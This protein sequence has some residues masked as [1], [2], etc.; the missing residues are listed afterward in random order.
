MNAKQG[1]PLKADSFD[2]C[3]DRARKCLRRAAALAR[4]RG[5]AEIQPQ[6]ILD[7]LSR[8]EGVAWAALY[9]CDYREVQLA[10][11]NR[12]KDE[13]A[14]ASSPVARQWVVDAM[15]EATELTHNYVG[16]EHL[17]LALMRSNP[18]LVGDANRVRSEV[19]RILGHEA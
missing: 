7:A 15:N 18:N 14:V 9:D 11:P 8:D 1:E 19:L 5:H 12:E 4:R 17:L 10:P 6:D 13:S 16:G 3:T 2:R